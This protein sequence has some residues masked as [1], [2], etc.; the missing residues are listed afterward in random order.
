MAWWLFFRA[1]EIFQFDPSNDRLPNRL[2]AWHKKIYIRSKRERFQSKE[3]ILNVSQF[4]KQ[5]H[6]TLTQHARTQYVCV[7]VGGREIKAAENIFF[8]YFTIILQKCI[9]SQIMLLPHKHS[10][11]PWSCAP[12]FMSRK[13]IVPSRSF[14]SSPTFVTGAC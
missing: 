6:D 11:R 7:C 10:I 9:A 1:K 12:I 5:R 4:L 14:F 13:K 8:F 3:G 2:L